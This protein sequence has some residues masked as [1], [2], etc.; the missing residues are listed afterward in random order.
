MRRRYMIHDE[1]RNDSKAKGFAE[2]ANARCCA[3]LGGV[4]FVGVVTIVAVLELIDGY[5]LCF[6]LS[7][8]FF[9]RATDGS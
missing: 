6:Q 9:E 4:S 5:G 1:D 2:Y 7:V 3:M 8:S